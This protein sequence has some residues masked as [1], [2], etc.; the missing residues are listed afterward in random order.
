[1]TSR[2]LLTR[3]ATTRRAARAGGSAAIPIDATS[4]TRNALLESSSASQPCAMD[5]IH[6][7]I[8]DSVCPVQNNRKFRCANSV[9]NGLSDRARRAATDRVGWRRKCTGATRVAYA[10]LTHC[11][12]P[13]GAPRSGARFSTDGA[14]RRWYIAGGPPPTTAFAAACDSTRTR[15]S[16]PNPPTPST[17][18]RCSTSWR[19][20]CCSRDSPAVGTSI[21]TG[22]S[23]AATRTARSTRSARRSSNALIES[24]QFTPEMLEALRG[25]G[26]EAAQAKLAQLLD[27]LVQR[28][29]A[30][31]YLNVQAPPQMPSG[32][33]PVDRARADSR[34]PPPRTCSSTSPRKASTSSATGRCATSSARSANPASAVTTRRISRPAS[35]PTDSASRT[36]SA[37]RSTWT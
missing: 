3:S 1:M 34:R 19:I 33:Q 5:C 30:E 11:D 24:G 31:G 22:V 35:R 10:I 26:D 32:Q 13:R 20:S 8:S 36:S 9:R 18:R 2:S 7:P 28:L 25:D 21:R 23:S 14:R 4:P 27:D 12:T 6:V 37:I 29:A 16:A 15:S 17:C